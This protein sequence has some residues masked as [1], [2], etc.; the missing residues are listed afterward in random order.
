MQQREHHVFG[1]VPSRRLGRS[2][3]VDL[4]PLKTCSYDCTYCQLGATTNRTLERVA[5]VSIPDILREVEAKLASAA[6][7]DYITLS[8]SGEPT[9]QVKLGT[10]IAGIKRI[11]DRPV[12]VLTN[13]SLLWRAD[14]QA[15][16]RDADLVIPSLDAGDEQMFQCVNRPH[17]DLRLAQVVDGLAAF[18]KCFDGHMWLEVFALAGLTTTDEQITKIK[19]LLERI[20]PERIQVN[21]VARPPSEP[22]AQPATAAELAH[23]AQLLGPQTEVIA[24]RPA[25]EVKDAVAA[26]ADEVLALLQRRPCTLE[27]VAAGLGAHRLEVAKHLEKLLRSSVIVTRQHGQHVYYQPAPDSVEP[28]DLSRNRGT[29]L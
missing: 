22:S 9:L 5:F 6:A 10:L 19:T 23:I 28:L 27:D 12:A 16:L 13:G 15:E 8:G 2:L 25:A 26:R 18:R 17:P 3:G 1:P 11:T 7:P 21:T 4:V 14:V 24:E 29:G 20:R